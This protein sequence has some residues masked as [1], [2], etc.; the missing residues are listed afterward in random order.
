APILDRIV[1]Q[2]DAMGARR[3]VPGADFAGCA[4]DPGSRVALLAQPAGQAMNPEE[5]HPGDP[6]TTRKARSILKKIMAAASQSRLGPF[7]A[8]AGSVAV[9]LVP[10]LPAETRVRAEVLKLDLERAPGCRVVIWESAVAV[11]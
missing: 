6:Y 4:L 1:P 11:E 2:T 10:D 7:G 5:C 3:I 9:G 8:C